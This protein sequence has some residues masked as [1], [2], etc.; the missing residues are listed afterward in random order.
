[1]VSLRCIPLMLSNRAPTLLSRVAN[2]DNQMLR[3]IVRVARDYIHEVQCW[4]SVNSLQ[5]DNSE[6][7]L[8][9]L[10]FV[11]IYPKVNEWP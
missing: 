4:Y 6:F 11:V 5:F 10:E 9:L 2:S 3:Q 8:S 1:M 7:I